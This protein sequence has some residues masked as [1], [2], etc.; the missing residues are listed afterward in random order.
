MV[1]M[2]NYYTS[3][4]VLILLRNRGIYARGTV[5]KNRRMVPS[6]NM[7]TKVKINKVVA[8]KMLHHA[9]L[10]PTGYGYY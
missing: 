9:P 10:G 5:K 2:D 6:K 1:N 7:L 3:P 8:L 4:T